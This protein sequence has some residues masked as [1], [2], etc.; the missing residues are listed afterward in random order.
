MMSLPILHENIPLVEVTDPLILN[1]LYADPLAARY[2]LTRVSDTIAVIAPGQVDAL[3]ARLLKTGHT[4][5]VM[6]A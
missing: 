4:P 2:L 3:L 1:D 5:K 6:M